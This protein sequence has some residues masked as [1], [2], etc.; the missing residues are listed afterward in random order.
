[1]MVPY[2]RA[3]LA[4]GLLALA[5]CAR[6]PHAPTAA[7][8]AGPAAAAPAESGAPAPPLRDAFRGAFLVGA[9][10]NPAQFT[11]R[12]ARAAA[13]VA[14]QFNSVSPENVLKWELVHPRPGPGGYDFAPA[15]AY[16][17][18]A[19]RHRMF[20]VGHTLV[21]HN[22]TPRWVFED[23]AGRPASRDTVLARMREHIH[24]VVGRYRGR[25]KGWDVVNE[26]LDED[27]S[28]RQTPWLRIVGDD[29]LVKAYQFAREADP[30]A[31]LY[32][33]DYSLENAPKRAGAVA[34]VRRLQAAGVPLKAVGTQ[35]HNKM[36]WP[37]V[38]Q[39]D[40]TIAALAATGVRVNVTELD[41]DVLPPATPS[42]GAEVSLR[43]ERRDS[44]D[45]YRAGLPDSVQR[46]LAAR[47]AEL[48]GVYLKH[49]AVIDRVTFWNV[50]DADSWL[51]DWPVPGR[52]AYPLLFDR[53]ARPK[54]AFAA[55]VRAARD[56]GAE[57]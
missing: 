6:A 9:A 48:F 8:P 54:P 22:Q 5:A 40:S 17:A 50:T 11:G 36:A 46:A 12:D 18:F 44:L 45:P 41:V 37:T 32:Y 35:E 1:M 15:D 2:R 13:L 52:T 28:L 49:R 34:L 23:A 20:A 26:A 24:T 39:V 14:A 47:Y 3:A 7:P 16:V 30:A 53:Q 56:A 29:Y 33:N 4:L 57:R 21:W 51:N 42:V 43:A 31:E 10:V 38:A 55:V 25:I 19:E 27:G